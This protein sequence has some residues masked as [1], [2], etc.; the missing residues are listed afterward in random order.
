MASPSVSFLSL[1]KT[2]AKDKRWQSF[3]VASY[4]VVVII[5][6]LMWTWL[7]LGP[8]SK[9]SLSHQI[10][11]LTS[12]AE[13]GS[14]AYSKISAA[15][16]GELVDTISKNGSIRATLIDANGTVLADSEHD[17]KEL[18]NHLQRPE[19][20]TAL[21]GEVGTD[22]RVSESDGVKRLYVASPFT[23]DNGKGVFRVSEP[24]AVA[25]N[26]I[27]KA[28]TAGIV[29]LSLVFIIVAVVG[30]KVM[31][32]ALKPVGRLERVRTDFVANASHELKTPVAGIKLLAESITTAAEDGDA[33]FV[34]QFAHRLN[35]EASRLENLVTDLLDLSRLEQQA[36][37]KVQKSEV[38]LHSALSTSVESRRQV[39]DAKGLYLHFKD[40]TPEK[41]STRFPI[42]SADVSLIVD[43]LID[44]AI[45]YTEEGG[46]TV[47]LSCTPQEAVISV[48]DTGIGLEPKDIPRIFERFYRVDVARS[49]DAG[50]T[51]LG[52]SLVR[53][54]VLS[55]KGTIEVD[56]TPKFG[57]T[58][59]VRIPR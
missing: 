55:A 38:D 29:L 58:F 18:T 9:N 50:G 46:V 35:D 28:Q 10:D 43:N 47:E 48:T 22:I 56:S 19:V 8:M 41:V 52:L 54:A 51:G 3:L 59:T 57:S 49:R 39:A 31:K 33:D 26:T 45:R 17:V 16:G 7:L 1:L 32:Q 40:T 34:I 24:L 11:E 13:S 12:V 42:T 25:T 15:D 37:S 44:N 14:Y 30:L 21:G 6:A 36:T 53:H 27:Y 20:E 23:T 4:L 5:F 2:Q